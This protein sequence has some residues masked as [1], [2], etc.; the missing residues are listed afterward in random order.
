ML[1][2]T[3]QRVSS[4]CWSKTTCH[5]TYQTWSISGSTSKTHFNFDSISCSAG[6]SFHYNTQPQYYH[7][8]ITTAI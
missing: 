6:V 5:I 8:T 2:I 4:V 1:Y 7:P 3:K